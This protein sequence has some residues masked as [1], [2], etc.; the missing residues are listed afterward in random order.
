MTTLLAQGR[1]ADL[2][3][4]ALGLTLTQGGEPTFVPHN[5]VAAEWNTAALGPEKLP[6]ARQFTRELAQTLLPGAVALHSSGKQFPGEPI[7]RWSLGLF[8]RR[9]G[10]PVWSDLTRLKLDDTAPFLDDAA[11]AKTVIEAIAADLPL[12]NSTL[13]AAYEDVEGWMR[14]AERHGEII[15][16]LPRF[17]KAV[18]SFVLPRE[19]TAEDHRR[20]DAFC[21]PRG[22]VLPLGHGPEG[23]FTA[24]WE[25]PPGEEITLFY[26]HSAAGL[27]LPLHRLP[28]KALRCALT[29]EIKEGELVVF[30]PPLPSFAVFCEL[31]K[32]IENVAVRLHLPPL[33][34]EGYPPPRE[35]DLESF[36]MMSDPGVIEVNL[37]PAA[38][39]DEFD[40]VARAM[41]AGAEAVGLR[42][43]KFQFS[44][45][46]VGTGGGAHIV[47]GGPGLEDNPFL[48]QPALL[49][50]FLRFIQNHPSLSYVFTA[51]FTGPSCQCPRVDESAH[52][53]PYELEI[54]LRAIERMPPPADAGMV[55]AILRNLL[56]DWNGNTHRA[57]TSIDKFHN[58]H[59][60]NG[61]LGLV[62]FR[63]FE[64]MPT[65]EMFLAMNALVRALAACLAEKPH[66]QP[67]INWREAL[68][69]QFALPHFLAEDLRAVLAHLAG[70]GFEFPFAWFEPHLD[71]RFPVISRFT[72]AGS[73]WTL[74][75][76]IEP[77]PVM[78]EM[79]TGS[80]G[81]ARSVD[82][83]TDRVELR[84]EGL[85]GKNLAVA[86]N[87]LRIPML[88]QPDGS[89]IGAVRY[90]LAYLPNSLQPQVLAHT[91]LQFTVVDLATRR[92]LH[93]FDYLNWRPKAGD[94]EGLPRSEAEARSR[95]QERLLAA[96]G[97]VGQTSQFREV[98]ISPAAPC[99]LDLRAW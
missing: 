67:L 29:V 6:F 46:K 3:L 63:A 2:K 82:A 60:P 87:G 88:P 65:A 58:A 14:H 84:A 20:W 51:L 70:H 24:P 85:A 10:P 15:P 59:A 91:P 95:V 96:S 72:A 64:M 22:W 12:G 37:P 45:R 13:Q 56:L 80:G 43:H 97:V 26:G 86:V 83:S 54:A 38:S 4:A 32:V 9:R 16:V 30:L 25:L 55:D 21:Q 18:R 66:T 42:G 5:T 48:K 23:W 75:Q 35:P 62:E 31:V 68:H 57:E 41:Y 92:I 28:E 47:L 11:L 40:R 34:L 99:T 52:E 36:S 76:A 49:P 77:W 78:G 53:L 44:G 50:G 17:S 74:R 39:W 8:R 71:F 93:A 7:P 61:R 33:V 1:L 94:Y 69:D 79:A 98:P 73:S 81:T 27:R 90:R 19:W 89:A